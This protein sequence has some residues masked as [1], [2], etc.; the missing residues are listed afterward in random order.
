MALSRPRTHAAAV[1]LCIAIAGWPSAAGAVVR[2][3]GQRVNSVAAP[4]CTKKGATTIAANRRVRVFMVGKG[5]GNVY[6]CRRDADRAYVLGVRGECQNYDEIDDTVVAGN[7]VALNIQTCGLTSTSSRLRLVS[8]LSGRVLFGSAPLTTRPVGEAQYDAIRRMVV[9][10]EG[11]L[12][13]VGVRV[14]RGAVVA[15]EVRRRAHGSR[16]GTVLLEGD[17]R[18]DPRSLR[19]RGNTASWSTAGATRSARI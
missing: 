15:A 14:E 3:P 11:R 1:A 10:A 5:F 9:T 2:E 18:I 19:R 13:W 8:L 6:G 4:N 17:A 16:A 12:A 7:L